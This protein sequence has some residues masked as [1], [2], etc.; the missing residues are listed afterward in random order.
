L[1]SKSRTPTPPRTKKKSRTP[2]PPRP[3]Q[4]PRRRGADVEAERRTRII[5]YAVAALGFV[6]LA[7]VVGFLFIGGGGSSAGNP[8]AIRAA[9]CTVNTY[10]ATQAGIHVTTPPKPGTYNSFPPTSGPHYPTPAP[11]D[12]YTQPV[13]QFRLVHNLEHGAVV[14]QYGN[15]VKPATVNQIADWYR[16]DPR[17]LVVA[18]LPALGNKIALGAWNVS[19]NNASGN[20]EGV[21]AKC[22]VFNEKAFDTFVSVYGFRGPEPFTRDMLQPGNT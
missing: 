10:P 2:A 17:G 3:V 9:G 5:L 13:Q 21:L 8:A 20:G 19:Q 6:G 18:P 16:K 12:L 15:K 11:Y 7:A 4:A 1:A 14:I 22:T